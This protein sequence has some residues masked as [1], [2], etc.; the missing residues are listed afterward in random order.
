MNQ[1]NAIIVPCCLEKALPHARQPTG[2]TFVNRRKSA[3]RFYFHSV[4]AIADR[5]FGVSDAGDNASSL[6]IAS[7]VVTFLS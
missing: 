7:V 3:A 4:A 6:Y 5:G 1:S 2:A